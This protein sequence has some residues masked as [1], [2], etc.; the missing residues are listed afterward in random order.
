MAGFFSRLFNTKDAIKSPPPNK[1]INE[2]IYQ[3]IADNQPHN[4]YQEA[5]VF[6]GHR[7]SI[8]HLTLINKTHFAT[9]SGD[10]RII[11]WNLEV[12]KLMHKLLSFAMFNYRRTA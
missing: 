10:C 11:L 4:V 12:K 1:P 9:A 6:Y 8:K 2:D 7:E 5:L 3:K